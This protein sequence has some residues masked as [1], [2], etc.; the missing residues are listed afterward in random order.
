[1]RMSPSGL[2]GAV[3][4][5]AGVGVAAEEEEGEVDEAVGVGPKAGGAAE[6]GVVS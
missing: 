6:A 3:T 4:G 5:A 1:M 2:G